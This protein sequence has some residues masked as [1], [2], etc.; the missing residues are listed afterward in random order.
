M[1]IGRLTE[2]ADLD[3]VITALGGDGWARPEPANLLRNSRGVKRRSATQCARVAAINQP[4][5]TSASVKSTYWFYPCAD[6]CVGLNK[7]LESR[8]TVGNIFLGT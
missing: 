8:N 3:L 4:V 7:D 1:R 6:S 2:E 5:R